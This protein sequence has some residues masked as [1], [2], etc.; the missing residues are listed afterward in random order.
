MPYPRNVGDTWMNH[1]AIHFCRKK[2]QCAGF[3]QQENGVDVSTGLNHRTGN[4]RPC[5]AGGLR[6]EVIWIAMHNHAPTNDAGRTGCN[7]DHIQHRGEFCAAGSIG[8]QCRQ[9]PR[10]TFHGLVRSVGLTERVEVP[11]GAHAVAGAAIALVVN[12]KAM[13]GIRFEAGYI[14]LNADFV[15]NLRKRNRACNRI[16]AGCFQLGDCRRPACATDMRT[17]SQDQCTTD[18]KNNCFHVILRWGGAT[19][20]PVL[21]LLP[22]LLQALPPWRVAPQAPRLEQVQQPQQSVSA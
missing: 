3:F 20:L 7:R 4:S 13:F 19:F 11:A 17:C 21:R 5:I 1:R 18:A 6:F 22:Q 8:L 16:A 14:C 2:P 10:M 9:V 12:M 15:T